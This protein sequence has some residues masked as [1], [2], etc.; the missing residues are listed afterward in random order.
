MVAGAFVVE[1]AFLLSPLHLL[2]PLLPGKSGALGLHFFEQSQALQSPQSPPPMQLPMLAHESTHQGSHSPAR[3]SGKKPQSRQGS[4]GERVKAAKEDVATNCFL[5]IVSRSQRCHGKNNN[6][7][8][9]TDLCCPISSLCP[10]NRREHRGQG[11]DGNQLGPQG[12]ICD[13]GIVLG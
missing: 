9:S 7:A 1:A 6:G 10:Y 4:A 12:N 11:K 13:N 8:R 2:A 3:S 5:R